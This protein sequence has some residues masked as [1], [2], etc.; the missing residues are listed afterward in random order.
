M[1]CET[2]SLVRA[3]S[4]SALFPMSQ[5]QS[6]IPNKP[7][8]NCAEQMSERMNEVKC[9]LPGIS[10][11]LP[12]PRRS[13]AGA[14]GLSPSGYSVLFLEHVRDG[15]RLL[16]EDAVPLPSLAAESQGGP[17]LREG[18]LPSGPAHLLPAEG[19]NHAPSAMRELPPNHVLPCP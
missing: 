13:E 16:P 9:W 6:L 5:A 15:R 8:K 18:V 17:V 19:K 14:G 12:L 2:V 10:I 7:S 3:G 4:A 1:S 11:R